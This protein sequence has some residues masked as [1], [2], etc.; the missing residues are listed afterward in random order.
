MASRDNDD[1][2]PPIKNIGLPILISAAVP[3]ASA[4]R[5]T[6]DNSKM[7]NG[8]RKVMSFDPAYAPRSKNLARRGGDMS[9]S[10]KNHNEM[11]T[12]ASTLGDGSDPEANFMKGLEESLLEQNSSSDES[13]YWSSSDDDSDDSD[14]DS[15]EEEDGILTSG[16][17]ALQTTDTDDDINREEAADKPRRRSKAKRSD[18]T[19]SLDAL[20]KVQ[21]QLGDTK[22]PAQKDRDQKRRG[23]RLN[24]EHTMTLGALARKVGSSTGNSD[25]IKE[26]ISSFRRTESSPSIPTRPK[27]FLHI[28]QEGS[29]QG[30]EPPPLT[31]MVDASA[32]TTAG[33][34]GAAA[35]K[36]SSLKYDPK[37]TVKPRDHYMGIL[38]K[39]GIDAPLVPY[40][41][42]GHFL[43]P[44]TK[45]DK[46]AFDMELVG[47]VRD[48]NLEKLHALHSQGHPMQARSQFGE[49]LVHIC[50][51]RGTPEMLRFLLSQRGDPE[52]GVAP[53]SCRLC[54]DYGRTPLHDAA[55]SADAASLE[56]MKILINECPD[57]LLILDR[58]GSMPL[59]YIPKDR[60]AQCCAFLDKHKDMLMPTGVLFGESESEVEDSDEE[61]ESDYS[62]ESDDE[63]DS[64]SETD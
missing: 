44:I 41:R 6:K 28:Q 18:S 4:A 49:S 38:K 15:D 31:G 53:V 22:K 16:D 58:R 20:L 14:D 33:P 17:E 42:L 1:G 23:R 62:L 27:R 34:Q 2:G 5:K 36:R 40:D 12:S 29:I 61:D 54:C 45:D 63:E 10:L 51:R 59:D 60:W 21:M 56:M 52:L 43:V 3:S 13:S 11:D 24:K 39:A 9:S 47:A 57:L 64:G 55:W 37:N 46:A 35:L 32:R 26:S 19:L 48:K 8:L 30:Q 25:S 7:K 50:A